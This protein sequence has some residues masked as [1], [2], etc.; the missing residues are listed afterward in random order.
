MADR[1]I[2]VLTVRNREFW[3]FLDSAT[4]SKN[5]ARMLADVDAGRFGYLPHNGP[6][7]ETY[8]DSAIPLNFFDRPGWRIEGS[9]KTHADPFQVSVILRAV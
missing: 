3:P 8:G 6:E 2:F 1:G 7:G 9:S 5:A 4:G